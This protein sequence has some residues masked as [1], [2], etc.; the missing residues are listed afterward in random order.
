MVPEVLLALAIFGLVGW[1]EELLFRGY[2]LQNLA[3]GIKMPLAVLFSSLWFAS[4][5]MVNPGFG[6]QAFVGLS[7]AGL[8]LAYPYL[9]THQL[10]LSIG[11]HIGWNFFEGT[12]FGF[13]VSGLN[14]FRLVEQEVSGPVLLSGGDFGPEAGLVLIPAALLMM[15]LVYLYTRNRQA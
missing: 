4:G 8:V 6:W 2:Y 3:D 9:C 7:L 5:H 1:N 12:I 13:P 14:L 11:L 15:G 10:W